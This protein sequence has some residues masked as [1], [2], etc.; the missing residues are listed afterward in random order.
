MRAKSEGRDPALPKPITYL[1]PDSFEDS[2]VGKI[3]KGWKMVPLPEVID[4]NPT[5]ALRKGEIAPYV[6]MANMPMRGHSPDS[7]TKRPFGSGMR[8]M[9]GDTLIAR[10]TPC[11]EN[12]KTAYVDFLQ[13]GQVALGIN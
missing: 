3:P 8:F 10:I 6:D 1:F 12:G 11:L 5:R 7:V 2:E 4:V 9:N 13:E